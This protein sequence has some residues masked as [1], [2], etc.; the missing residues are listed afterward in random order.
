MAEKSELEVWAE[1]VAEKAADWAHENGA[2]R[3]PR[4]DDTGVHTRA[5]LVGQ[6]VTQRAIQAV[7][8]EDPFPCS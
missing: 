6:V 1:R 4:W 8:D 3:F 5:M 2:G 7:M